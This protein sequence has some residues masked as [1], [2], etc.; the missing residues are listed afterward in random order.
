MI[1]FPSVE[2]ISSP[3]FVNVEEMDLNPL[4]SRCQIKVFYLG[5]NRNHSSINKSVAEKMA[6][7]LR[8]TP[9]VGYYKESVGDFRDHGEAIEVD[10]DKIN[11]SCKT[12]PYGFVSP[13]SKIWFQKYIEKDELGNPIEREYLV[14]EGYLWTGQYPE[15]Q[16]VISEGKPHSMELYSDTMEGTWTKDIKTDVEFFIISDATFYKLC[17]LGDDVEPC[18]EGSSISA[19]PELSFSLKDT[20]ESLDSAVFS[21]DKDFK[22]SLYNMMQELKFALQ[23]GKNMENEK[24][25]TETLGTESEPEV[26]PVGSEEPS[27]TPIPTPTETFEKNEEK[28][29]EEKKDKE[30][31]AE[32]P[33]EDEKKKE[34]E[35]KYTALEA[36]FN[37][38]TANYALIEEELKGLRAFK[39]SAEDKEKD[40]LISNFYMLSEEDKADVIKNKSQYSLD[41][42]EQKLS[43]ICF[44]KKVNF[45]LNDNEEI[46]NN[47]EEKSISTYSLNQSDNCPAWIKAVKQTRDNVENI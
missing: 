14:C 38:L 45:N 30:A 44:R 17:I 43:V 10:Y 21:I 26:T 4:M 35:E 25:T 27:P 19:A 42:I 11:F 7:T 18:Y 39:A 12:F 46:H 13:T 33:K 24:Q 9:I 22:N 47:T 16:S 32:E 23:G 2:M 6:K 28:E 36:K 15:C 20:K 34:A 37:E 8:G 1:T 31:P 3:E 40:A 29:E 5:D 41:E